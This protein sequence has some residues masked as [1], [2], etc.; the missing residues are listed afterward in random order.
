MGDMGYRVELVYG[1]AMH[2]NCY[3]LINILEG[4][5]AE[6]HISKLNSRSAIAA[7]K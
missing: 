6:Q 7:L 1:P 3:L 4:T 2:L 5:D